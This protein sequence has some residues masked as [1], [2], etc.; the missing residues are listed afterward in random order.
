M[1]N[2]WDIKIFTD[3]FDKY[4]KLSGKNQKEV[5]A[6]VGVSAPT[7]NDWLKG[8]KMPKMP[9]VQK[10]ADCFGVKLS[11]LVEKKVTKEMEKNSDIMVDITA[12][13]GSDLDF[14]EIVKRNF[15]DDDYFELCKVLCKL[16]SNQ[17]AGV[18]TM[19]STLLK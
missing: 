17:I 3:N 18:K 19:L 14:R 11:D 6:A 4:M 2:E 12:R 15:S 1:K 8:K 7:V 5:A 9:N 16:D 10:L 13:I